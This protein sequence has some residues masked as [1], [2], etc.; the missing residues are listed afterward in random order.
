M[1]FK[2][3]QEQK[4][5]SFLPDD[6]QSP[7]SSNNYVKLQDGDNKFRILSAPILGW[8]DWRDKTPI[9]YRMNAKPLAPIDANKPI[10]H[11]WAVIV[12]NYSDEAIQIWFISQASIRKVIETLV[13]DEEWGAPYFYDIKV[14]KEGSNKETKYSVSPCPHKEIHSYIKEQF[15]DKPCYLDA[16]YSNADPFASHWDTYTSLALLKTPPAEN[17]IFISVD[18]QQKLKET[19]FKDQN[20]DE[21]MK[22]LL[23]KCGAG[24]IPAIK[25]EKYE[26]AVK[27]LNERIEKQKP[28]VSEEDLP[29]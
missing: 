5:M 14:K 1:T 11:F 13:K 24:E 15:A 10:K 2:I 6:Y 29:F 23:A 9:R 28:A 18:Q 20:A 16:L 22:L 7:N 12:W 26:A 8:E 25:T 21:A 3:N 17:G 27:W 4:L 19:L